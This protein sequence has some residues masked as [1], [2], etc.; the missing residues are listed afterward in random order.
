MAL[1][2]I[3]NEIGD[4]AKGR[5]RNALEATRF[6]GFVFLAVKSSSLPCPAR[7]FEESPA[8]VLMK[9]IPPSFARD[10]HKSDILQFLMRFG[11]LL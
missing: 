11:W 6:G 9:N 10:Q 4:L 7:Q 5:Q 3:V 2:Q 1:N 8:K